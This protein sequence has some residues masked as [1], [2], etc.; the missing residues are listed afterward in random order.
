MTTRWQLAQVFV[1]FALPCRLVI[2]AMIS[3]SASLGFKLGLSFQWGII[4]ET[5]AS[6]DSWD[7][8]P[9]RGLVKKIIEIPCSIP[10]PIFLITLIKRFDQEIEKTHRN[11]AIDGGSPLS[12]S[13]PSGSFRANIPCLQWDIPSYT[14]K[15]QILPLEHIKL[16]LNCPQSPDFV[17]FYKILPS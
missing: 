2:N 14:P 12:P 10:I 9:S 5:L 17:M 7:D 13:K 1:F 4:P 11:P 15:R 6:Y 3:R 8:P 16:L